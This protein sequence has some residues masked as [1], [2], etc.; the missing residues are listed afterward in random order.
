[1]YEG[2]WLALQRGGEEVVS[3]QLTAQTVCA[4]N[5]W[6]MCM[7]VCAHAQ[8]LMS[9]MNVGLRVVHMVKDRN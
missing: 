6:C 4:L 2:E 8:A 7:H 1:M 5:R 3:H 9:Q